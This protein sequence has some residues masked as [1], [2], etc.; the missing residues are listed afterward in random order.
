M[1]MEVGAGEQPLR[2]DH[3]AGGEGRCKLG[4]EIRT[5]GGD[6][7]SG[8]GGDQGRGI[9]RPRTSPKLIRSPA[10]PGPGAVAVMTTSSPSSRNVRLVPS[11]RS[12]GSAP[13]R[14]SSSRQ[15]SCPRSGPL[16]VPEAYRSP[17][18]TGAP[19]Q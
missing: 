7:G 9:I 1:I 15:P 14:V 10:G 4:S 13:P 2:H 6:Q 3:E 11:A 19:P 8:G 5:G 12:S 16:T 17:V 18:R